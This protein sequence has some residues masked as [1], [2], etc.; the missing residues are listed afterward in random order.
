M[1]TTIQ[2]DAP[3]PDSYRPDLPLRSER[4]GQSAADRAYDRG[5]GDGRSDGFHDRERLKTKLD[6][7]TE[8]L[9]VAREQLGAIGA[10]EK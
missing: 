10:P 1:A 5:F 8:E 4:L 2:N 6:A 9:R 3:H 7:A